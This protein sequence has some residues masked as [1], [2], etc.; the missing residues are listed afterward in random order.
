MKYATGRVVVS[1]TGSKDVPCIVW[2][3]GNFF[4][5]KYIF[6]VLSLLQ[7][8]WQQQAHQHCHNTITPN[9]SS[10]GSRNLVSSPRYIFFFSFLYLNFYNYFYRWPTTTKLKKGLNNTIIWAI[11]SI[12]CNNISCCSFWA[13]FLYIRNLLNI[14]INTVNSVV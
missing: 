11:V 3:L 14:Q 2:A 12:P 5:L 9:G 10:G 6:F 1:K 4:K 7:P 13:T 8:Q